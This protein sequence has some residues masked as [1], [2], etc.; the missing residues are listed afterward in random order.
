MWN[1]V[2]ENDTPVAS[3]PILSSVPLPLHFSTFLASPHA[4]TPPFPSS[5]SWP[6]AL[7]ASLPLNIVFLLHPVFCWPLKAR[8]CS[9]LCYHFQHWTAP[10]LDRR[11]IFPR[12][13]QDKGGCG[14]AGPVSNA[15]S[16]GAAIVWKG[17]PVHS[18]TWYK[19]HNKNIN[20]NK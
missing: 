15:A 18:K 20:R 12:G 19:H 14:A 8:C 7:S 10:W 13:V 9:C 6:A 4:P 11:S 2:T 3:F 5:F 17:E 1:S 16:E